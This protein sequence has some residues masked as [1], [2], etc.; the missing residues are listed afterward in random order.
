MLQG[1]FIRKPV[2]TT[3]TIDKGA[4]FCVGVMWLERSLINID[5]K[6]PAI[7]KSEPWGCHRDS[8]LAANRRS[9]RHC[10]AR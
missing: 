7:L 1:D 3:E 8:G 9:S 6:A 2:L 10:R 5:R 4:I